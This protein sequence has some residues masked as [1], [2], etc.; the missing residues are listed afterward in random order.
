MKI[1]YTIKITNWN[2]HYWKYQVRLLIGNHELWSDYWHEN[3]TL[4]QV[5][6]G[7]HSYFES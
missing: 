7:L 2:D 4:E 1:E 5:F 3:P 6:Y